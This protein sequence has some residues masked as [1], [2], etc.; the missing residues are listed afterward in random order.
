MNSGKKPT[1]MI[2]APSPHFYLYRAVAFALEH[3]W[4][5]MDA[6]EKKFGVELSALLEPLLEQWQR[7]GIVAVSEKKAVLTLAGQFWQVNI[8]QLMQD[9]LKHYL[10]DSEL[11]GRVA[12]ASGA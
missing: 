1:A 4:I 10:E 7:A 5:D 9:F 3:G 12:D 2:M 6:L 8:S 11:T